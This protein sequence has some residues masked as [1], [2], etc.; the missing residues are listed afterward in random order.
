[1]YLKMHYYIK[2]Y[3]VFF[4]VFI[5]MY[6]KNALLEVLFSHFR[7]HIYSI[8]RG[9]IKGTACTVFFIQNTFSTGQCCLYITRSV[10]ACT[11]TY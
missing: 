6:L 7:S 3:D 5:I 8:I 1:M 10:S 4:L 9:R 11:H 2:V